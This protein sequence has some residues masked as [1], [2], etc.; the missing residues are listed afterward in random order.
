MALASARDYAAF[1]EAL[2]P[3]VVWYGT[4]G[5]MDAERVIRGPD[6]YLEYMREILGT[7][8]RYEFEVEEAFEIEDGI[9]VYLHETGVGRG[10]IEL[11]SR[12]AM[13]LGIE[14]GRVRRV[15][16]YLDRDEARR[17]CGL[18]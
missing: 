6:A 17:D 18:G 7:L 4:R 16:G 3:D 5:G 12:T 15:Q 8:E 1:S 2:H 10:G 11:D 14:D 9:L 13:A